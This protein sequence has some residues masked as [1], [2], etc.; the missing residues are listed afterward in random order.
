MQFIQ[1]P[2]LKKDNHRYKLIKNL[3]AYGHYAGSYLVTGKE[4]NY[5][6]SL[7][8]ASPTLNPCRQ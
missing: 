5:P 6:R 2:S 8:A 3:K 7:V 4:E 1:K